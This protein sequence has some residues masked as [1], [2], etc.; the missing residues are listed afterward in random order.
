MK[1][2]SAIRRLEKLVPAANTKP[3]T[4]ADWTKEERNMAIDLLI[5]HVRPWPEELQR[6]RELTDFGTADLSSPEER[7]KRI[8]K[9]LVRCGRPPLLE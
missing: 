4:I 1:I 3:L 7:Q 6:K 2:Y 8:N 5:N 9:L